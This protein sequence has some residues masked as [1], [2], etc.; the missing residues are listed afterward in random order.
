LNAGETT[1][2]TL[3]RR[4]A[5]GETSAWLRLVTIYSPLVYEWCRQAG[6]GE[7]EFD[8]VA[9]EVFAAVASGLKTVHLD[10]PRTSFR[11]WLRGI[12]RQKLHERV[13]RS[14][15]P[16]TVASDGERALDE[17]A[18]PLTEVELFETERE[19]TELYRRAL[20]CLH[21]EFDEQTW[22]AFW[23]VAIEGRVPAEVAA[24]MGMSRN[25]VR[26]AKAR[27]LRRLKEEMGALIG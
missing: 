11:D 23:Q 19:I 12:V 6:L 25:E 4:A 17:S 3:L 9:R 8:D 2:L 5:L 27:V 14:S 1:S 20:G 10:Q 26:H 24:E 7:H 13:E 16:P 22:K 18:A 21:S 15:D